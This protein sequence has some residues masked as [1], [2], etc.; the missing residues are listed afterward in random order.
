[1]A[2]EGHGVL[3]ALRAAGGGIFWIVL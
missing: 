3:V 2:R 1:M